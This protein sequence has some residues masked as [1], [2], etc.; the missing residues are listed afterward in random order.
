MIDFRMGLRDFERVAK[1]PRRD[2]A[3]SCR[4]RPI[5]TTIRPSRKSDAPRSMA[6]SMSIPTSSPGPES[7]HCPAYRQ[8]R[9]RSAFALDGLPLGVQIMGPWLEDPTP[10]K[11][12]ELIEREF[13]GFRQRSLMTGKNSD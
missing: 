10:L 5:R 2:F 6:R 12:A 1:S 9:F 13:G 11:L 3:L 7:R 8:P 4:P